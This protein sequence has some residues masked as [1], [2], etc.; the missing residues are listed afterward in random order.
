MAH[1]Y[2]LHRHARPDGAKLA[3]HAWVPEAPRAIAFYI[4]GLQSHGGWLYETGPT[5]AADD[6]AVYAADRR[7]SGQS[8]GARG[9]VESF[10]D[11]IEDYLAVLDWVATKHAGLALTI[12][13]QSRGGSIA[14]AVAADGRSRWDALLFVAPFLDQH[15]RQSEEQRRA[16]AADRRP[17]PVIKV[18][19]PDA[20]YTID[21]E[22]LRFMAHDPSML[23]FVSPRFAAE[24]LALE[25]HIVG[26]GAPFAGRPSLFLAPAVDRIVDLEIARAGFA[27]LTANT[28]LTMVCP[29]EAH[30]IEFSAWRQRYCK[31]VGIYAITAGLE[32]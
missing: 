5:I 18:P 28:G 8:D 25:H 19:I 15:F 2:Q 7:G 29:A 16:R 6:I 13:G 12:V 21:P 11:W 30:Y 10:H 4:H 32:R 9:D 31:L 27:R 17:D 22:F 3:V 24:L 26:L 23:R 14:T 20:H 1:S